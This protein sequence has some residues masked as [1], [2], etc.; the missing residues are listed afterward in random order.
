MDSNSIRIE[1][2]KLVGS[3]AKNELNEGFKPI[4]LHIYDDAEGTFIYMRI[5]LK[6][7]DGRKWIR[8]FHFCSDKNAWVL[9]E[10][11][12]NQQ[13]PLYHLSHIAK[14]PQEE[15][16]IVEGEHKVDCLERLG[17]IAT[18]SGG[19]TSAATVDWEPLRNR[20]VIIW[21]DFDEFGLCYVQEV[22]CI[23]EALSCRIRY[24]DVA[25]LSN[26]QRFRHEDP[27]MLKNYSLFF[28]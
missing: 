18:T 27:R 28:C 13:K 1:A 15:V 7:S 26:S 16:W 21:R 12:F 11:Q 17:C 8:P 14:N 4:A 3:Y 5:R 25:K 20:D 24:V 10:P 19:C 6:H 23:L 9:G 22:R 2:K